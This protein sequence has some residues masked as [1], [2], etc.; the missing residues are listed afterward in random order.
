MA[1]DHLVIAVRDLGSA[2]QC[3]RQL[4]FEVTAGGRH[5]GRGTQNAIIRF[6]VDYL[7]L[8]AVHDPVEASAAGRGGLSAFLNA[9]N[10]G[11]VAWALST[12][13]IDRQAAMLQSAGIDTRGPFAMERLRPDG[14]RLSWRLL[15]P[16]QDQYRQ[17]WPFF[18]QWDQ[19][20]AERLGFEQPGHHGNGAMGVSQVLVAVHDM[21]SLVSN[22]ERGFGLRPSARNLLPE[23]AAVGATFQ[24]PRFAIVLASPAGPGWLADRL[25]ELGEGLVEAKLR[26]RH[27]SGP[28][29]LDHSLSNG[30]R[31]VLGPWN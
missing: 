26:A 5:P 8:I 18:I 7:E 27:S 24:L 19:P 30:A 4:G 29:A 14:R 9:H 20:A 23:L 22:Y 10:G 6:G 11:L 15:V 12:E 21:D 2:I 16:G 31:L 1:F 13:D 3:Y 28:I 25:E 17:P